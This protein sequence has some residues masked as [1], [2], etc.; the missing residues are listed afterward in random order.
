MSRL[1]PG[2]TMPNRNEIILE[3]ANHLKKQN[4]YPKDIF[5]PLTREEHQKILKFLS[6][7]G[8]SLDRLYGDWSRTI[9][10]NAA[11]VVEKLFEGC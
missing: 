2:G 1:G 11:K 6:D 8:I 3:V 10:R 4:P 9:W 5:S 7:N